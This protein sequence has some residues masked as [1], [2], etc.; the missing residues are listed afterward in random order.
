MNLLF[1]LVSIFSSFQS[2]ADD[3]SQFPSHMSCTLDTQFPTY[4]NFEISGMN[5]LSEKST[6]P[7]TLNGFSD[8]CDDNM[9][10][11]SN[12]PYGNVM[13][14]YFCE[15]GKCDVTDSYL[16]LFRDDDLLDL[17]SGKKTSIDGT[18]TFNYQPGHV[19]DPSLPPQSGS[20]DLAVNCKP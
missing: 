12:C 13:H 8:Y 6:L 2:F 20:G 15:P 7:E 3:Y 17:A 5:E 11:A 10:G 1:I 14:F 16:I 9:G 4:R 18:W 19:Q